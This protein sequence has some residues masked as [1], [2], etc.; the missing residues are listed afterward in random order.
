MR[1]WLDALPE[2]LE[3]ID[4]NYVSWWSQGNVLDRNGTVCGPTNRHTVALRDDSVRAHSFEK[5]IPYSIMVDANLPRGVDAL[6]VEDLKSYKKNSHLCRRTDRALAKEIT[7]TITVRNERL[8]WLEKCEHSGLRLI[9]L[10]FAKRAEIGPIANNA[11]SSKIAALVQAGPGERSVVAWNSWREEFDT[12]NKVQSDDAV[13]EGPILAQKYAAAAAKLGPPLDSDIRNEIR[14]LGYKGNPKKTLEAITDCI[15]EWEANNFQAGSPGGG[16]AGAPHD[17]R[18]TLPPS[19]GG[20]G[21]GGGGDLPEKPCYYCGELHWHKDCEVFKKKMADRKKKKGDRRAAKAAAKAEKDKGK[22]SK[23]A[24]AKAATKRGDDDEDAKGDDTKSEKSEKGAGMVA[25]GEV[26]INDAFFDGDAK[27]ASL[28]GASLA[29]LS[30]GAPLDDA[31]EVSVEDVDDSASESSISSDDSS[32]SED[33]FVEPCPLVSASDSEDDDDAASTYSGKH[34]SKK[35]PAS[36]NAGSVTPARPSSSKRSTRAPTT[37]ADA[38]ASSMPSTRSLRR[39][40]A[41]TPAARPSSRSSGSESGSPY[42]GAFAPKERRQ[43]GLLPNPAVPSDEQPPPKPPSKSPKSAK[44]PYT[45][46]FKESSSSESGDSGSTARVTATKRGSSKQPR[47]PR[48]GSSSTASDASDSA[49]RHMMCHLLMANVI[50]IL[51]ALL[52]MDRGAL[53]PFALARSCVPPAA[54]TLVRAGLDAMWSSRLLVLLLLT[55]ATAPLVLWC[56]F[57]RV[58]P[59]PIPRWRLRQTFHAQA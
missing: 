12:W 40:F 33:D 48:A 52:W 17:P 36:S 50:V 1:A 42:K 29:A 6:S 3:K 21:G 25:V 46:T 30:R 41:T 31:P 7:D 32:D 8:D 51:A 18:K 20:S 45:G 15:S 27:T 43:S 5:P 56:C 58:P 9:P 16:L 10:L 49:L 23:R 13:L 44:T 11:A 2:Y 53:A 47:A 54:A 34:A 24:A 4:P 55:V 26:M 22:E 59:L 57:K 39:D 38:L 14:T 37:S 28:S 35:S 19:G